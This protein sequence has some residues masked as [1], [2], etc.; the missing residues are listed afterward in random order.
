[1][2]VN[3]YKGAPS[4]TPWGFIAP[5][6]LSLNIKKQIYT[7]FPKA[8][9]AFFEPEKNKK[10]SKSQKFSLREVFRKPK[11]PQLNENNKG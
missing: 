11:K 1:M 4:I 5:E 3:K 9:I 7:L 6:N 10:V 2:K 8:Y